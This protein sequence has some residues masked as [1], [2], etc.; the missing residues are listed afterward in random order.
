M[1]NSMMLNPASAQYH[2]YASQA[3][4]KAARAAKEMQ[5][6]VDEKIRSHGYNDPQIEFMELIGKGAYGRVFKR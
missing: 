2:G 6:I 5:V 1:T 3:R 4:E